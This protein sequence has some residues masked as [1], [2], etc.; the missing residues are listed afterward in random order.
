[1]YVTGYLLSKFNIN[2]L[3]WINSSHIQNGISLLNCEIY[4]N[5][6][7]TTNLSGRSHRTTYKSQTYFKWIQYNKVDRNMRINCS[8]SKTMYRICIVIVLMNLVC[9]SSVHPSPIAS[10]SS[11]VLDDRSATKKDN[12]F[13]EESKQGISSTQT[14]S[15]FKNENEKTNVVGADS[16][17]YNQENINKNQ[18][19]DSG[20]RQGENFHQENVDSVN[21]VGRKGGHRKGHHKS[22][23]HNSY[24]K[25]ESENNSSYYDD[26][27]DQGGHFMY[28]SRA[29]AAGQT[30]ADRFRNSYDN[31]RLNNVE[32]A[33]RGYYDNRGQYGNERDDRRAF[34]E[35][36]YYNDRR[37]KSHANVD[38]VRGQVDRNY[39][40]G[41]YHHPYHQRPLPPINSP[42]PPVINP[43]P[44]NRQPLQPLP[45][46]ITQPRKTIT[47]YEDPR[48]FDM[49]YSHPIRRNPQYE[50]RYDTDLIHL[51]FRKSPLPYNRRQFYDY[52]K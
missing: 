37:D 35:Q 33:K 52:Y 7:L 36:Q 49:G 38:N 17:K 45:P 4:R 25:D 29:G 1:M 43:L 19:Q 2:N 21:K 39:Q 16:G 46:P 51:D 10:H 34:N 42:L 32:N 48:V 23:Y 11:T 26:S 27:D 41:N 15:G 18:Q 14:S 44:P 20:Q 12:V 24:H 6:V 22:G 30:G 31:G 50:P 3:S 9:A 5:R 28:D 40:E 8:N 47:I 13:N